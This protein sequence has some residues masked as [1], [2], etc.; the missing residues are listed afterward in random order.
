MQTSRK[1]KTPS[2]ATPEVS[3]INPV[4]KGTNLMKNDISV[5]HKSQLTMSSREIAEL[6]ESRHDKFNQ[7]I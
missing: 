4:T 6:V 5:L 2:A 3:I 7:S 1:V